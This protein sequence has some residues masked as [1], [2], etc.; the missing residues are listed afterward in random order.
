MKINA[1]I[2]EL[3]NVIEFIIFSGAVVALIIVGEMN[4]WSEPLNY[5]TEPISN[6]G[7]WAPIVASLLAA[8]GSLYMLLAEEATDLECKHGPCQRCA[9]THTSICLHQHT[10][11]STAALIQSDNSEMAETCRPQIASTEPT[12]SGA[13]PE[14]ENENHG[15]ANSV[16]PTGAA[17]SSG[18]SR[19]RVERFLRRVAESLQTP[20]RDRY[21][22]TQVRRNALSYPLVPGED[23]RVPRFNEIIAAWNVVTTFTG[24][25]RSSSLQNGASGSGKIV[26]SSRS[27]STSP[28]DRVPQTPTTSVLSSTGK[29]LDVPQFGQSPLSMASSGAGLSISSKSESEAPR[30]QPPAVPLI[31]ITDSEQASEEMEGR[32]RSIPASTMMSPTTS[33]PP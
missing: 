31:I 20:S 17:P 18:W 19:M 5:Q 11:M 12:L 21:D 9:N 15:L 2:R 16:P 25:S 8:C 30:Q 13:N 26:T 1:T 7:Q 14:W 24:R 22:D 4:F 32:H 28:T 23:L 6:I 29:L 10:A 33:E 27:N 3:L